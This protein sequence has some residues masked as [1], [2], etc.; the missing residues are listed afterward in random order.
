MSLRLSKTG[1]A[2]VFAYIV[3]LL[4]Y[5]MILPYGDE[6]DFIARVPEYI[7]ILENL[8]LSYYSDGITRVSDCKYLHN[9]LHTLGNYDFES[10]V[11][12]I[13]ISLK[14]A[15][16]TFV[17]YLPIV[18]ISLSVRKLQN[19]QYSR[20]FNGY[21][22]KNEAIKLSLVF[23]SFIYFSSLFSNEQ[24]TLMLSILFIYTLFR[25]KYIFAI[26]LLIFIWIIDKGN[27][28]VVAL[29]CL[30]A[31]GS[32]F[33]YRKAG[34]KVFFLLNFIA[35]LLAYI[36]STE[37]VYLLRDSGILKN[38]IYLSGKADQL[39]IGVEGYDVSERWPNWLRPV[40]TF[41]SYT[42]MPPAL[43]KH[44]LLYLSIALGLISLL[45]KCADKKNFQKID[46]LYLVIPISVISMIMIMLF[47][48][49][50]YNNAKYY[51]F[52]LP[53]LVNTLLYY[54]SFSKIIIYFIFLNIIV[55]T[56]Y[57]LFYAIGCSDCG[58]F[59]I[60]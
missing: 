53:F 1:I 48:L 40:M 9:P 30:Y 2:S 44:L 60:G 7:I 46:K 32:I 39:I 11:Q 55:L 34:F 56:D 15:F 36:L 18:I 43:S 4:L 50:G 58:T 57:L 59:Y 13:E 29:I 52:T 12:S 10:C 21:S 25:V 3:L 6:P 5:M 31:L 45:I 35:L 22:L 41:M 24:V 17:I 54:F 49:P 23:P 14:R 8:N 47:I 16:F 38:S 37:V 51:I 26:T 27:A 42:F 28:S 20:F 19:I 33:I